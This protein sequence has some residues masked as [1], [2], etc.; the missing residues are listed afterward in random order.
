MNKSDKYFKLM[1]LLFGG[2]IGFITLVAIIFFLLKLCSITLF[3]IPGFDHLF[4]FTVIIIP[5]LI[6]FMGYYYLNSKISLS[7]NKTGAII[8]RI[9]VVVGSLLCAAT[10]VIATLTL[11]GVHKRFLLTYQDNSQYGWIIQV[12]ILFFTA[13]IIASGDEKEKDWMDKNNQEAIVSEVLP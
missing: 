8:G 10:M 12:V 5:Y 7:K 4:Q 11:F 9:F 1:A 3:Y 13:L 6:F 2:F